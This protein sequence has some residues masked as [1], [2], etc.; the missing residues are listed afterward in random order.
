MLTFAKIFTGF[1]L[2]IFACAISFVAFTSMAVVATLP[3]PTPTRTPQPAPTFTATLAQPTATH[4][5]T[6][7]PVPIVAPTQP[8]GQ[9]AVSWNNEVVVGNFS[10]KVVY[11]SDLG[12]HLETDNVLGEPIDSQG[13]FILLQLWVKNIGV[14]SNGFSGTRLK[15]KDSNGRTY[16]YFGDSSLY[17]EN[18][19]LCYPDL[20]PGFSKTCDFIFEVGTDSQ[21]QYLIISD[22]EIFSD[23]KDLEVNLLN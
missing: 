13:K 6:Q 10:H 2:G 16:D 18:E 17:V 9:D 14:D 22:Q 19:F 7:I 11:L 5:T 3:L 20:Q 21:I 15:L 4:M 1:L 8:E 12:N 23:I